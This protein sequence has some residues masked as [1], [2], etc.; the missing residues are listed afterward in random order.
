MKKEER[1]EAVFIFVLMMLIISVAINVVFKQEID[2]TPDFYA[3]L[4]KEH[5]CFS[6]HFWSQED[7]IKYCED[8]KG[9]YQ[10]SATTTC[11]E[12]ET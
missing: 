1:Y 3:R 11:V 6:V 7:F 4:C 5:S 2:N 9:Q 8:R 12:G 10:I